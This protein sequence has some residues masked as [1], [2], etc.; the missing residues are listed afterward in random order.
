[1]LEPATSWVRSR[2]SLFLSDSRWR[3]SDVSVERRRRNCFE[4]RT[5]DTPRCN[6]GWFPIIHEGQEIARHGGSLV[7]E[8]PPHLTRNEGVPGS[9]PG[10][11]FS[12]GNPAQSL[13][14]AFRSARRSRVEAPRATFGQHLLRRATPVQL[15]FPLRPKRARVPAAPR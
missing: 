15:G 10:V 13:F 4:G 11:G 7:S 14:E 5:E 8:H 12:Q 2:W 6:V 1:G 3:L 9:S